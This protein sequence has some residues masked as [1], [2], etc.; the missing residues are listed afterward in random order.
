[1]TFR[2]WI[3][4]ALAGTAGAAQALPLSTVGSFCSLFPDECWRGTQSLLAVRGTGTDDYYVMEVDPTTGAI[5]VS[6]TITVSIPANGPTGSAVPADADYQGLNNG[7]N[8]IGA[9]GDSSGRTIV[10]GDGTAG[11]AAGGVLTVQGVAS[12]TPL[13][14]ADN[15]GSITV[16]GTV[17]A[18]NFPATADTDYGTPGASTLR[19]AAMLGVGAAAAGT[20]NPLP[21]ILGDGTNV[22]SSLHNVGNS[23]ATVNNPGRMIDVFGI[24]AG[25]DSSGTTHREIS[26]A[27]DGKV[28]VTS[29]N[30]PATAST[31]LGAP[32]AST[33][34][35]AAMLGVGS[36]AV[37]NANP[38]PISDAGGTITVDGT[39]SASN[40]PATVDTNVGAAGASTLRYVEAG[41]PITQTVIANNAYASTNVTTAA[42]VQLIAS[43]ANAINTV[44]LSDSSGSI[45]IIATGGAGAETNRIYLPGGGA[46]CYQ[47]NIAAS[48]R[49]SLK[50]LDA[51]ATSGYFLFTGY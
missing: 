48:T 4:L 21:V 1:M 8:L 30:F 45:M 10:A 16:D 44:C 12:M 36:T 43:T 17:S 9:K 26:V 24:T 25:W 20:T 31:D 50:A 40:F 42:Y 41:T 32:G 15:G 33:L 29:S 3:A 38:V 22:M 39:V 46:G 13:Q 49:I 28:N 19:T 23:Q 7:G 6:G 37:S 34:R 14:I 2:F 47:V 18:S 51:S 35:T 27:S 5:P 11:A